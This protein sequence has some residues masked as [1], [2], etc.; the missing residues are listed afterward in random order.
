MISLNDNSRQFE[1]FYDFCQDV[2]TEVAA[3]ITSMSFIVIVATE[4]PTKEHLDLI[5]I[6]EPLEP[7]L[8][9]T[10]KDT[11]LT[12]FLQHAFFKV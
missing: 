8:K 11:S 10:L 3:D 6:R 4:A 2:P 9:S 7:T 12:P 1:P 5:D